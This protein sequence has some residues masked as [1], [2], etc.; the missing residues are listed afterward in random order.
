MHHFEGIS[1][2][3]ERDYWKKF[4]KNYPTIT[5]N[6]LCANKKKNMSRLCFKT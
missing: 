3:S 5:V 2:P 4:E 6:V 1:H